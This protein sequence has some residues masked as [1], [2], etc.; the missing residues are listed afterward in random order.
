[1]GDYEHGSKGLCQERAFVSGIQAANAL[2]RA[3][4]LPFN[5]SKSSSR[6]GVKEGRVLPVREDEFQ[7]C[8]YQVFTAALYTTFAHSALELQSFTPYVLGFTR[9]V[10]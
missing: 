6:T 1:M 8:R 7:V 2:L 5:N 9:A 10:C 3:G 4:A